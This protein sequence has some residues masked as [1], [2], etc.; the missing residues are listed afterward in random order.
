M[1]LSRKFPLTF[2]L[3]FHT[4]TAGAGFATDSSFSD[5]FGNQSST[6]DATGKGPFLC[7]ICDPCSVL[8]TK[9]FFANSKYTTTGKVVSPF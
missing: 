5:A 9:G 4:S 6:L 1:F 2:C 3:G 7:D 8:Y